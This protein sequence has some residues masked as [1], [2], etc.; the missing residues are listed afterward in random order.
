MFVLQI[1]MSALKRTMTV[2]T[3]ATTLMEVT[4]AAV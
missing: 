4:I 3:F 1:L 2:I